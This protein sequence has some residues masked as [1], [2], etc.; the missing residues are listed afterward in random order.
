MLTSMGYDR[1]DAREAMQLTGGDVDAAANQLIDSKWHDE[2]EANERRMRL[3]N[4]RK[5]EYEAKYEAER[6]QREEERRQQRHEVEREQRPS[7]A[8]RR[9][10]EQLHRIRAENARY[11]ASKDGRNLG[12]YDHATPGQG[13][14]QPLPSSGS[15]FQSSPGVQELV[16]TPLY[17]VDMLVGSL[18]CPRQRATDAVRA[19][20]RVG[21]DVHE[22]AAL[23]YEREEVDLILAYS[24]PPFARHKCADCGRAFRSIGGYQRHRD[25]RRST[26][27]CVYGQQGP[28]NFVESFGQAVAAPFTPIVGAVGSAWQPVGNLLGQATTNV[29]GHAGNIGNGLSEFGR[30]IVDPIARAGERRPTE[31][32]DTR[33]YVRAPP[34]RHGGSTTIW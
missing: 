8:R 5:A 3:A 25:N 21:G 1:L 19:A 13:R 26:G 6:R 16:G 22:A 34:R 7:E 33:G 14:P 9:N 4:L 31:P 12:A 20:I 23:V 15:N 2:K 24:E 28:Q 29:M 27:K 11:E 10:E 17:F 32:E 18:R 30:Q